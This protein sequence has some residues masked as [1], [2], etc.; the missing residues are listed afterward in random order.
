MS[1][2]LVCLAE[3]A[4]TQ[5]SYI[6]CCNIHIGRHG[7][8]LHEAH[9]SSLEEGMSDSNPSLAHRDASTIVSSIEGLGTDV[10]KIDVGNGKASKETFDDRCSLLG[11]SE[12]VDS[13]ELFRHDSTLGLDDDADQAEG[14]SGAIKPDDTAT[15]TQASKPLHRLC[16]T[17]TRACAEVR[18]GFGD[19]ISRWRRDSELCYVICEESFPTEDFAVLV[20]AAMRTAIS[21]WKG[22]G[23][24]FRQVGRHDEA[25][26][27]V[28]YEDLSE[29]VYAVSFF[30]R[31]SGGKLVLFEP[32][33]S[34][35]GYLANILA[36]EIGHV[37]GLR[38]EFAHK[39]EPE[40][41]IL[42][43]RENTNSVMNY[44]DQLSKYQVTEQDLKELEEFYAYDEGELSISDIDPKTRPFS[45]PSNTD[46][47]SRV[48][49]VAVSATHIS[50]CPLLNHL[51]VN[52]A[53]LYR[54]CVLIFIFFI[55]LMLYILC[56][57][58]PYFIC[59]PILNCL[60]FLFF[61]L[62]FLF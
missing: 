41:S 36:H 26:F 62:F 58:D 28:V 49:S 23:V 38:H 39:R 16:A 15:I 44:F 29:G 9:Y 46:P 35:T 34:N 8:P 18:I 22:I 25:T 6:N 21:M 48:N 20:E 45:P 54:A 31:A 47:M 11:L 56:H 33:L 2:Y 43:G 30:P 14:V 61:V 24:R 60:Y 53:M 27:A 7:V 32:S 40:P 12:S 17:Q 10:G 19:Q 13:K 37:L 4:P 42:I 50:T 57:I 55:L 1:T 59:S 3:G 51:A 52:P 5:Q